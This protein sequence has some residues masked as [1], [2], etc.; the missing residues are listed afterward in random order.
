[1]KHIR[2]AKFNKKMFKIKWK[3]LPT[4]KIFHPKGKVEV[5]KFYGTCDSPKKKSK[6]EMTINP[7]Q[8]E[9]E[10]LN[11]AVHEAMHASDFTLSEKVVTRMSND[12]SDF[13]W[14]IGARLNGGILGLECLLKSKGL[15]KGKPKPTS[16][17]IPQKE[18]QTKPTK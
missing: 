14:R 11:T 4:V 5:V 16:I 8:R 3:E 1:M 12:I 6:R 15:T 9:R 18:N 7:C 2:K 17:E 10:M 13:L